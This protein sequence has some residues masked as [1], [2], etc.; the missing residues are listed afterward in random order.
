[1]LRLLCVTAH[2]DDEAGG[3]GG[4][5]RLYRERG[6]ETYVICLTPGQAAS[7]RG[8]TK[9][10]EELAAVRR[11]EFA[12]SCEILKVT[13]GEVLD[14]RDAAL[15]R[16]DFYALVGD[17]THRI[18]AIRPD[19]VLTFGPEGAITAHADH[20]MASVF[21][22]VAYQWAA[23][24][25]RFPEQLKNG[26]RPY[27]PQKL[28]YGT[29]NFVLP[30]R[31]PVS[32]APITAII[33]IGSYLDIKLRAFRAHATQSPLFSIFENSVRQRGSKEMFHLAASARPRLIEQETDLFEGIEDDPVS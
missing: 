12:A 15:D 26:L 25:N 31:Q 27:R 9:S 24:T 22:T 28:Y 18:R 4:S 30:G 17:L 2:P 23:R 7:H 19:I 5:L 33:E 16:T 3:F 32:L 20:G 13:H 10:D 1:M 14:Y 6:V 11:K 29:A 21:T 8:N